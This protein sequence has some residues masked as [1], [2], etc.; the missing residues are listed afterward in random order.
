VDRKNTVVPY[1]F[2]SDGRRLAYTELD[3]DGGSDL[4][5]LALDLSD[6]DHPKPGTPE[7][8]LRTSSNELDPAVS[9]DGEWIACQSDESGRFEV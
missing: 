2:F 7:P 5:T 6:P 8:F 1:S 4:W 3:T 9:P